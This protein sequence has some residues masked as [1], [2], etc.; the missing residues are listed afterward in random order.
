MHFA[1]VHSNLWM[2]IRMPWTFSQELSLLPTEGSG[3]LNWGWK[4]MT[5]QTFLSRVL[6]EKVSFQI[7]LETSKLFFTIRL[8][9]FR[10]DLVQQST[11]RKNKRLRQAKS[12]PRWPWA[13]YQDNWFRPS[14]SR[15][16]SASYCSL[17][18]F[19]LRKNSTCHLFRSLR[20]ASSVSLQ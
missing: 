6:K 10:T 1:S 4:P 13:C 5:M 20:W 19:F 12:F 2:V 14:S 8:M 16:S 15:W 11:C 3:W 18:T 9:L 17:H 7:S